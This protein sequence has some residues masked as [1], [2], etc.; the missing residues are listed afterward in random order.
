MDILFLFGFGAVMFFGF[1]VIVSAVSNRTSAGGSRYQP[2]TRPQ[3][4]RQV[5]CADGCSTA[6]GAGVEYQTVAQREWAGVQQRESARSQ[7]L[8][9]NESEIEEWRT[10]DASN[11]AQT[12]ESDVASYGEWLGNRWNETET[13]G[14]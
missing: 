5:E 13:E 8:R 2:Y 6:G 3:V 10:Q 1:V 4:R 9:A 11:R 7:E 12:R 14:R